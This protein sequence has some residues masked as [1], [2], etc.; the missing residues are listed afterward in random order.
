MKKRRYPL[1]RRRPRLIPPARFIRQSTELI[2]STV[3]D[4][5]NGVRACD[6]NALLQELGLR[7]RVGAVDAL[8]PGHFVQLIR[9][10]AATEGHAF[11]VGSFFYEGDGLRL[12]I[13]RPATRQAKISKKLAAFFGWKP[14]A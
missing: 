1:S 5:L 3:P 9:D 13:R 7:F 12:R 8:P 14:T 2:C 10:V 6:I 4:H 11:Q